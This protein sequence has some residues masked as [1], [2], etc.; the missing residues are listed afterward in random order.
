MEDLFKRLPKKFI[1]RMKKQLDAEQ[2]KKF[3]VS[4]GLPAVRG[5]RINKKRVNI[6][7]FVGDFDYELIGLPFCD[8]GFVL[9]SE[10]KLGNLPEHLAGAIYLQEPSS[11]LAVCASEIENENRPLKVGFMCSTWWEN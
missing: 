10:Q 6:D 3:E 11:M 9:N 1:E 2:F 7:R 5:L 4:M 8:D